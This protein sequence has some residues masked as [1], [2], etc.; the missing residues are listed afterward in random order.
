LPE[1]ENPW[2]F[3]TALKKLKGERKQLGGS[4]FNFSELSAEDRMRFTV[5]RAAA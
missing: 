3:K 5:A 1:S 2:D 4:E